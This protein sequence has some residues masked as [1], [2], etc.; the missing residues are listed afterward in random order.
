M[1]G[2]ALTPDEKVRIRR[3]LGYPNV[4]VA[5][6]L[7]FGIPIPLTMSFLVESSM[8]N[9]L[10]EAVETAREILLQLDSIMRESMPDARDRL[11]VDKLGSIDTNNTELEQLR[12]DR[13][14]WMWELADL[15]GVPPYGYSMKNRGGGTG[16]MIRSS[17]VRG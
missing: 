5:A 2:A 9:I 4:G 7:Q 3:H 13:L 16:R 8:S 15:L 12:K 10:P 6:S 1:P 17:K 14:Y 11:A